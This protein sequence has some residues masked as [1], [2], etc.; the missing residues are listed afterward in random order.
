VKSDLD[1]TYQEYLQYLRK[2]NYIHQKTKITM[3]RKEFLSAL[4]FSAASI[5]LS[6]C[7]GGCKNESP[8]GPTVD[9]TIDITN[10]AYVALGTAGGYVYVNGV[11]VAKTTSGA[12]IAVSQAC[13]HEG[14]TVEYQGNN[15]RF[16][17]PRHGAT[18]NTTG[19]V[20]AGPA[21]TALK[22]YTVTVNGNNVRI[23][24]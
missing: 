12:I 17:C 18:F 10:P 21:S 20:T 23:N 5:A 22:Q 9:F 4:G 14:A 13:T 16:Y 6:A 19:G 3:D 1:L 8:S 24:G 15:N 2:K 7:L 11:I